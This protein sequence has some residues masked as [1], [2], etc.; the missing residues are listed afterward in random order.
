MGFN[1]GFKG[2]TEEQRDEAR[3]HSTKNNVLPEIKYRQE[4]QILNQS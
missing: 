2:L 3:E 4:G 1:S